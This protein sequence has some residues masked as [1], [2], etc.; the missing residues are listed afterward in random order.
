MG[1][2][3]VVD[4]SGESYMISPI[5]GEKIPAGKM[6]EHMRFSLLDPNWK[7]LKKKQVQEKQDEEVVFAGGTD[8]GASLRGLAERRTDIFGVEE[9]GLGQKVG[10][11]ENPEDG[12][13]VQWDGFSGSSSRTQ[14]AAN[15]K[16]T[17]EEQLRHIQKTQGLLVDENLEKIG[18]QT[19]SK[20]DNMPPAPVPKP[21]S[22]PAPVPAPIAS[23]SSA[24]RMQVRPAMQLT[25]V[26]PVMMRPMIPVQRQNPVLVVQQQM[27]PRPPQ[28]IAVQQPHPPQM[29]MQQHLIQQPRM[30]QPLHAQRMQP[31]MNIIP[32]QAQQDIP[33]PPQAKRARTE[34]D[35]V[36]QDVF[37]QQNPGPVSFQ[38]ACP[39]LP[40]KTEW[41]CH[42]RVV[43]QRFKHTGLLQHGQR[44]PYHTASEGERW[45][46][47]IKRRNKEI[48]ID[49]FRNLYECEH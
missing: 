35:L 6:Q 11:E 38:V 19:T 15:E 40:E 28:L 18:P 17:V 27:Q 9:V 26:T 25:P 13:G 34:A 2:H 8:I 14:K 24:V 22:A 20:Q 21:S 45:K 1:P 36:P 49:E 12:P 3:E 33:G 10:E 47:E 41:N 44:C 30:L 16:V 32:Q 37:I 43:H 31:A 29:M 23:T 4:P 46:K 42:G 48:F 5:T 39:N 7:E